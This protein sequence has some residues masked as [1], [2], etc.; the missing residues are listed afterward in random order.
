MWSAPAPRPKSFPGRHGQLSHSAEQTKGQNA[1]KT[2]QFF[3]DLK[4]FV[5]SVAELR[6]EEATLSDQKIYRRR[7]IVRKGKAQLTYFLY[8]YFFLF[9]N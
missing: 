2:E 3:P 7:K 6:K 4:G 1:V 9:S 8:V 5:R